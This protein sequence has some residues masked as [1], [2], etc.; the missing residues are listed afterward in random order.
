M[1]I[2]DVVKTGN[3]VH[4]KI[5]A[6]YAPMINTAPYVMCLM[7]E[8]PLYEGKREGVGPWKSRLFWAQ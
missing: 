7:R 3:D 1:K 4:S 2:I 6:I 8:D 5:L